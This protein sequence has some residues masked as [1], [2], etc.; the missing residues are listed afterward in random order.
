M[1]L[2]IE[3][4]GAE[5]ITIEGL[6]HGTELDEMQQSFIDE[7]ALQCGY[8]T[9]GMILMG[10]ALL[11]ENPQPTEIEVREYI[12]GNLCRCTGYENIIKAILAV[13]A[14]HKG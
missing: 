7:F 3:M 13:A 4:D 5:V 14:A 6:S 10:K 8:C 9:P 12:G 1:I 2:A 11:A